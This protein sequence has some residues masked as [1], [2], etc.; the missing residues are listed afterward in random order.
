MIISLGWGQKDFSLA[1]ENPKEYAASV[2]NFLDTHNLDGVDLDYEI[3]KDPITIDQFRV[4]V[5]EIKNAIGDE[6]LYTITPDHSSLV[7]WDGKLVDE[8]FDY[9]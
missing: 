9:V 2:K 4:L 3:E 6:K 5:R 8:L 1:A 7:S